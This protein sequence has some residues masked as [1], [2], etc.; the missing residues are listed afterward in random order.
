VDT[1]AGTVI[2]GT[3]RSIDLIPAFVEELRHWDILALDRIIERHGSAFVE[4]ACT[5]EDYD[6]EFPEA[7]SCLIEDLIDALDAAAPEGMYFGTLEGDGSDFGFWHLNEDAGAEALKRTL[8][9]DK[10]IPAS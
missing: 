8:L 4:F 10:G 3:L 6:T 1:E 5:D 9:A 7:V 2:H